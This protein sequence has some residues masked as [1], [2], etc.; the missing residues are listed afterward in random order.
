MRLGIALV[1][2]MSGCTV[3]QYEANL[4][5]STSASIGCRAEDIVLKDRKH[6]FTHQVWT[7]ECKGKRFFCRQETTTDAPIACAKE[8]E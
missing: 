3:A 5:S 7:A 6:K 2:L 1:A 8:A 4:R